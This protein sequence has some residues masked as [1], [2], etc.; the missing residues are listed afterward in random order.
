MSIE[1]KAVQGED[2][3]SETEHMRYLVGYVKD[4]E[5]LKGFGV[6]ISLRHFLTVAAALIV[7]YNRNTPE[8]IKKEDLKLVTGLHDHIVLNYEIHP[9]S[10]ELHNNNNIAVILVCFY[11]NNLIVLT[12]YFNKLYIF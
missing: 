4:T 9:N 8:Y 3:S 10:D 1:A 11:I 7:G 2:L 6:F 12:K 5:F